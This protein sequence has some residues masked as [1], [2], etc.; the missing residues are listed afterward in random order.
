M[1]WYSIAEV[2][3]NPTMED[4]Y[5][6]TNLEA[7]ACEVPVVT[8]NTGGSPESVCN[9]LQIIYSKTIDESLKKIKNIEKSQD[10]E[11]NLNYMNSAYLSIY[12]KGGNAS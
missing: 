6:T 9:E 8:F 10:I 12:S 4:N 3:F 1:K 7:R 11:R 2:Y 5:P